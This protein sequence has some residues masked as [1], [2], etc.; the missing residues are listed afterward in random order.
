MP[1]ADPTPEL[2]YEGVF[3]RF[4]AAAIDNALWFVGLFYLLGNVPQSVYDDHP[5]AIG[6]A[7][8]AF[9]SLWFNYFAFAEWRWGKTVGK[10]VMGM[11]VLD[12][13]GGEAGFGPVS[14]RNLLRIVDFFLIGPVM[15]ASSPRRQRLGD[16]LGHT[17]VVSERSPRA[18]AAHPQR[19]EPETSLTDREHVP[20]AAP[21]V[22]RASPAPAAAGEP[23]P[24][25]RP[26]SG[27]ATLARRSAAILID[28][29]LL[30]ALAAA[31]IFLPPDGFCDEH[32]AISTI[33]FFALATVWFN[34]FLICEWRWG[35]RT[36]GKRAVGIRVLAEDGSPVGFSAASMRNLLRLVDF[37]GLLI[38]PILIAG[39]K[40]RQRI[41]DQVAHT[42]VVRG[43]WAPGRPEPPVR[44]PAEPEP[45]ARGRL[46]E[47][48]WG[49]R[50]TVWGLLAG[51]FLAAFVA[52]LLVLPFDHDL[53][54]LGATL[55]AQ[56]LLTAALI[57]TAVYIARRP[58]AADAGGVRSDLRTALRRLGW[59]RFH[60]RALGLMLAMLLIYYV[61]VAIYA[62]IVI[63]PK[64]HDIGSDLGL[65]RGVLLAATAVF[66]I[67]VVAPIAEETFFR[68]FVF[69]GLR[70][71]LPEIPSALISGLV[72]G[73]VHAPTGP[74]AII[75]LALLGMLLAMLFE[76]TGSIWPGV[77][78]HAINNSLALAFA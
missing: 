62:T 47:I 45:G 70:Q 49:V 2:R 6:V 50:E 64:Q 28:A 63:E 41:G 16:R 71:R 35:G 3:N 78:A 56:A 27:Y 61:L 67:C 75:P 38:G 74:T 48:S 57:G 25:W 12:E 22:V 73:A 37:F 24:S 40:R 20:L 44:A 4:V 77:I 14:V 32:P 23:Q 72:F 69:S 10:H 13:D 54:S 36:L 39:S 53:S 7:V 58:A 1:T 60:P 68:G 59:R 17:V 46:P 33:G 66:L 15:I 21:A 30:L 76:R 51:L 65:N 19:E 42:I 43:G 52:P 34:Y 26:G 11:R 9:L 29:V 31:V 8:L 5:V 18:P 55:A